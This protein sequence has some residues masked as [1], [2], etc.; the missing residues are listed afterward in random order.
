MSDVTYVQRLET[1]GGLGP[2]PSACDASQN[3]VRV[4]A[5]YTATYYFYSAQD[6]D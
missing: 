1:V 6:D 2:A 5:P 3:G 4:D